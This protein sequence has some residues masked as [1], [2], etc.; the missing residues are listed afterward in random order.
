ME[1]GRKGVTGKNAAQSASTKL[2][3]ACYKIWN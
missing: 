3:C 2:D 1:M